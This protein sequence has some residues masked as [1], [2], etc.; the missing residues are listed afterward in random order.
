MFS[1]FTLINWNVNFRSSVVLDYFEDMEVLPQIICLQEVTIKKSNKFIVRLNEIGLKNYY[2]SGNASSQEKKYG[3]LIASQWPLIEHPLQ[4]DALLKWPQLV[5]HVTVNS[6]FG[7]LELINTHVPN[8]SSNGWAKI[9]T[10]DYIRDLVI[11][12]KG[13][14]LIVAGDFNEPQYEIQDGRIVTFGQKRQP[15][16]RYEA[17]GKLRGDAASRWNKSVRWLFESQNEHGLRHAFWVS[18]GKVTHEP[19][20]INRGS[21]R[22]FDHAFISSDFEVMKCSYDHSVREKK[23]LSDHSSLVLQ[24]RGIA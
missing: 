17:T 13:K 22:W 2:F 24:L 4:P 19:T 1:G 10:I 15:N 14:P 8:G 9:D 21:P 5:A 20:H 12:L 18:A 23:A 11:N 16:G 6:P 3:N 7:S